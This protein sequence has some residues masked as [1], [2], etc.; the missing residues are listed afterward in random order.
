VLRKEDQR[1]ITGQGRYTDDVVLPRQAYAA[2][3]RS[4]HAHARIRGVDTTR[5]RAVKGVIAVLTGADLAADGIKSIPCYAGMSGVADVPLNTR[6]GSQK[7]P[8]PIPLL[9]ADTARFVGDPVAAVIGETLAAAQEGA[10]AVEVDYDP[11]TAVTATPDAVKSDAPKV[12][13]G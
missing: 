4:P 7:R 9:A 12:W 3:V 2:I 1:L 11:I 10:E 8:T 13:G 6:E 5:A